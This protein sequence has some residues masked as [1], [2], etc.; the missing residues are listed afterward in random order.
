MLLVL[1]IP[2]LF[3]KKEFGHYECV[4]PSIHLSRYLL[5]NYW[6]EFNQIYCMTSPH[7]KGVEER[8]AAYLEQ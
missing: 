4:C 2:I 5:L 6:A 3:L 1:N 8:K 7:G